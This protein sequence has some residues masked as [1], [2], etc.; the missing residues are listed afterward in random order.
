MK[1]FIKNLFHRHA[2]GCPHQGKTVSND[3]N[4]S[5]TLKYDYDKNGGGGGGMGDDLESFDYLRVIHGVFR[6]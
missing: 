4:S 3:S 2:K 6:K 5:F 1:N